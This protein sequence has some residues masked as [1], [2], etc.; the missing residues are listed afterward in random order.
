[1]DKNTITGLV[2]IGLL[3]LGFM[4]LSPEPEQTQSSND[5]TTQ[6]VSTLCRLLNWAGSRKTSAQQVLSQ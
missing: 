3:F 1:M 4:W 5:I 2:L 6:T